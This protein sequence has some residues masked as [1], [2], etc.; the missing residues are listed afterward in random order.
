M[1]FVK[2]IS[3]V[4][5]VSFRISPVSALFDTLTILVHIRNVLYHQEQY[6]FKES[7]FEQERTRKSASPMLW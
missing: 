4:E 2:K 3:H 7:L 5:Y 6:N 1:Q